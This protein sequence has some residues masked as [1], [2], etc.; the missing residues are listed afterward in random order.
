MNNDTDVLIECLEMP[1]GGTDAVF[2]RFLSLPNAREYSGGGQR[3]FVY[4]PG[5]RTDRV[6]LVAHADTVWHGRQGGHEVV[7][8]NGIFRSGTADVGIGADDRAGCAALWCLRESGHSLLITDGEEVK[9]IEN[10]GAYYLVHEQEKVAD[11]INQHAYMLELDRLGSQDCKYYYIPV[12]Y[13]FRQYIESATGYLVP[14]NSSYTDIV[15]LCREICGVNLSIGYLN[16]HGEEE[17]LVLDDWLHTL[18]IVRYML[19]GPQ[20]RFPQINN[21]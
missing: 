13:A 16:E 21:D 3:R 5:R 9:P 20:A 6:L 18:K 7:L 14:D 10:K 11:E 15:T 17:K 19:A 2:S 8:E 1:L 4:V 12:T